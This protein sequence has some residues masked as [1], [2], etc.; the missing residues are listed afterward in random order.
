[1]AQIFPIDFS[2]KTTIAQNDYILFSDS[3]DGN[4]IKKAQ[5]SNLKWEKWDQWPQ[6]IQWPQGEEWPQWPQWEQG[7]QWIQWIQGEQWIQW[8]TW[9]A[10]ASVTSAAFNWND[11]DFWLSDWTTVT[12]EDAK[13]D[14]KWDTWAAWAAATITVGTTTTWE[15]WTDASV[16]N[17]GTSSAAVFNFTIPKGA[18][19]D[20]GNTWATW[21][22]IN[23]AAFSGDD[24]VFGL[25]DS[26]SVTLANAVP[27]LTW[28]Q[29]EQGVQWETWQTWATGNWIAS[30]TSSK[31]GKITTVTITETDWDSSSFQIS[32]WAD[33]QW[34]WDVVWPNSS[35]DWHLAVFDWNTW[36]IIK[37]GWAVPVVPTN[38]SD[39]TNDAWYVTDSIISDSAYGS[40]W[41]GDTTHAPTKNAVYD[42]IDSID[43]VIPSAAT[44][45]NKLADKNYVNDSINSVTAYYI[46]KDAAWNQFSTYAELS[47]ASTFYSWGV[48]RTPTRNDYCIVAS[49]ENH[50]NATTRYIYNSG[51]EYQYTVN[52]TALTTAQ[53][54]ALN[55]WITAAKVT[56][57]DW[58]ASWKQ[59]TLT[60]QTAYTNKW[61][62]SKVPTIT[63]NTLWQV[64]AITETPI[65]FPAAPVSSVNGQTWDVSLTIPTISTISVT[66]TS[67]WWSSNSQTVT[68]TWVTA[69]N[70]V[71][72]SPAPANITDYTDNKVYCS[73]QG[74]N[75]LT[76][77]CD[78]EPTADIVVNVVI[79]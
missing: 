36:K 22:K 10:W 53:L 43:E 70:T 76:F 3:E 47:S 26:T 44:S 74:S 67:A 42:K 75:S 24:I 5:Y 9:E 63:T 29:W 14:L 68:A 2:E 34:S 1:M 7:I 78:T 46:T 4:K 8:E 64:T 50:D 41:D 12:L 51:W 60:T 69:S 33:W 72:V 37:D 57:Y 73:A 31:S 59:D 38:V 54:N 39:F 79:I 40:W 15:P 55:S 23:S 19:W 28:P 77:S 25:T 27:T 30:I 52:E 45:S 16:T 18:K 61:T 66:L 6:G 71:I 62:A 49:D 17:S 48:A 65:D 35:T 11:I 32:D 21:A 58:Y 56:T 20:T 13:I